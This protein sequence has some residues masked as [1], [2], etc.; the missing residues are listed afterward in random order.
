[1]AVVGLSSLIARVYQRPPAQSQ[2][3]SAVAPRAE[4]LLKTGLAARRPAYQACYPAEPGSPPDVRK[5]A[6]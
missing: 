5:R 2:D 1:M 6:S 3:R 4:G